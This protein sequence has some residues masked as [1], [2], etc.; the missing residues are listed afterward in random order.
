MNIANGV[1]DF[2]FGTKDKTGEIKMKSQT[3]FIPKTTF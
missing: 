3:S 2:Y 1:T